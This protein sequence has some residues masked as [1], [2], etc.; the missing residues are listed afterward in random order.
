LPNLVAGKSI[1]P[2]L[3][4]FQATPERIADEASRLLESPERRR[5]MQQQLLEVRDQ[6]GPP[7][8]AVRAAEA[9]LEMLQLN[10][11]AAAPVGKG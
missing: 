8:A 10:A 3:I 2:E 9:V 11:G 7:G 1:V 6:L 4:Q 5:R